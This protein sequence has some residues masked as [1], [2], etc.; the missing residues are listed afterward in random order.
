MSTGRGFRH[1]PAK[2]LTQALKS[3]RSGSIANLALPPLSVYRTYLHRHRF[4]P[5]ILRH[6]QPVQPTV[7]FQQQATPADGHSQRQ[8]RRTGYRPTPLPII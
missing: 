6:G 8:A 3:S 1:T 4:K 5:Q 2:R 7:D